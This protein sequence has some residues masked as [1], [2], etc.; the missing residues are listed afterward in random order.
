[1]ICTDTAA[2]KRRPGAQRGGDIPQGMWLRWRRPRLRA[3]RQ[4]AV[5]GLG[6][7]QLAMI[8]ALKHSTRKCYPLDGAVQL[9]PA[10]RPASLAYHDPCSAPPEGD[11]PS[12]SCNAAP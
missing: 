6:G 3:L 1:M 4:L 9:P 5:P 7:A 11:P 12:L 8:A 10:V 2:L